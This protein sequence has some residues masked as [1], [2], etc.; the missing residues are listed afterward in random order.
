MLSVVAQDRRTHLQ[1]GS[2][3]RWF[4][5]SIP[6]Q[7][8]FPLPDKAVSSIVAAENLLIPIFDPVSAALAVLIGS[9]DT[10]INIGDPKE[11]QKVIRKQAGETNYDFLK[12]IARE[13]G[14]EMF[15]RSQRSTWRPEAPL[16]VTALPPGHPI[17][18]ALWTVPD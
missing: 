16:H 13:N 9:I 11:L 7:G 12:R 5:L 8:N 14:W 1:H 6:C 17:D 3:V 2:A 18:S 10:V 15:D 4:A